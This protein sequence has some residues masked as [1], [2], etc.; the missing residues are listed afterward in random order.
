MSGTGLL[1]DTPHAVDFSFP[2]LKDKCQA[3]GKCY[4]YTPGHLEPCIYREDAK[5]YLLM[6]REKA[7]LPAVAKIE[8][9][10]PST[11][12]RIGI[13]MKDIAGKRGLRAAEARFV[14]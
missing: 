6:R 1:A 8:K 14:H 12:S 7:T 3:L 9:S 10:L 11:V 5:E 13:W 2:H 4:V